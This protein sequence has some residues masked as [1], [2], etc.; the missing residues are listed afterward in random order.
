MMFSF[1]GYN[2]YGQLGLGH[3]KSQNKPIT[4]M[5]GIP[6]R[7]IACGSFSYC[8]STRPTMTF[9]FLVV[10][11]SGQL[12]LGHNRYQNKPQNID[13]G[14]RHTQIAC[15]DDHNYNSTGR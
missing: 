5:Q 4:L 2:R 6:I 14:N 1:F 3:D 12:G 8:H 10:N 15:G 9:S 7:Q 11:D 13:A